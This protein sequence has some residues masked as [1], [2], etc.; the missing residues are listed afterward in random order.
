MKFTT[1]ANNLLGEKYLFGK[2]SSGLEIFLIPKDQDK[3]FAIFG[4]RYGAMDR[5]FKTES[6]P[7]YLTVPDGIAHFLEH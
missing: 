5:T 2:H 3:G 6:D 7:D 1:K 4:T